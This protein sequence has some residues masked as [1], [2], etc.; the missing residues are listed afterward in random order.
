MGK[1]LIILFF[2]IVTDFYEGHWIS[3]NNQITLHY[4]TARTISQV[5]LKGNTFT[6]EITYTLLKPIH[7]IDTHWEGVPALCQTEDGYSIQRKA[8]VCLRADFKTSPLVSANQA[9]GHRHSPPPLLPQYHFSPSAAP[10]GFYQTLFSTLSFS[11]ISL[12]LILERGEGERESE[13]SIC[14]STYLFIHWLILV[15]ALTRDWTCN[16]GVIG[17]HSNQLSTCQGM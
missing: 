9:L 10:N 6:H 15:C 4:Q 5:I 11:L 1:L 2:N 17:Q 13:T 8:Q 16:L 12:L 14:C 7:D 3:L